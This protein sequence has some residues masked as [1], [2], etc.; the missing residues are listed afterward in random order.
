MIRDDEPINFDE[1]TLEEMNTCNRQWVAVYKFLLERRKNRLGIVNKGISNTIELNIMK[2]KTMHTPKLSMDVTI[3]ASI[4]TNGALDEEPLTQIE[5]ELRSIE[6]KLKYNSGDV[7][8]VYRLKL[9]QILY[10]A[11][12]DMKRLEHPTKGYTK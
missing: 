7:F 6:Q 12:V 5:A 10:K 4:L 3:I 11:F 2:G 1:F 8:I 9:K